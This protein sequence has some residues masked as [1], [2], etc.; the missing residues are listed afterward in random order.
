MNTYGE[1]NSNAEPTGKAYGYVRVST[2]TQADEGNGLQVQQRMLEG[3]CLQDGIRMERIFVERGVSGSKPIGERPQGR[4]LLAIIKPGDRI[5]A[6]KLDRA[7]RSASDALATLELLRERGVDLYLLDMGG[8]ITT[9]GTS[10]LVF[11]ILASVSQF[12]RG[13]IAERQRDAKRHELAEGRYRG[14]ARPF[15]FRPNSEKRLMPVPE[16]QAALSLILR[17]ASEGIALRKIQAALAESLGFSLSHMSIGRIL[18]D[19]RISKSSTTTV[20]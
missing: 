14:G 7:F 3:R 1:N 18:R 4:E 16:E 9:G 2:D 19:A 5:L 11:G 12:E 8:C 13:R 15:G 20:S 17:L 10:A 6:A